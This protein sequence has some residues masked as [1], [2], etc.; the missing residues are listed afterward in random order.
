MAVAPNAGFV[1]REGAT[2]IWTI[3]A[4]YILKGCPARGWPA[5]RTNRHVGR[6]GER[7]G[8]RNA[9]DHGI[10]RIRRCADVGEHW[11]PADGVATALPGPRD[12][13]VL[14]MRQACGVATPLTVHLCQ[15]SASQGRQVP[16]VAWH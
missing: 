9:R 12:P 14:L 16:L 11:P 2:P 13:V 15:Q 10:T 4:D 7:R 5:R 3:G 8:G 6:A 1:C